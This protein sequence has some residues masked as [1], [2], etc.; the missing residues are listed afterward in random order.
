MPELTSPHSPFH[1]C[2]SAN[3]ALLYLAWHSDTNYSPLIWTTELHS[4]VITAVTDSFYMKRGITT[5]KEKEKKKKKKKKRLKTFLLSIFQ[6]KY[7]ARTSNLQPKME[8]LNW[9]AT[10]LSYTFFL[11]FFFLFFFHCSQLPPSLLST[12]GQKKCQFLRLMQH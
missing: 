1:T 8:R 12:T 2:P 6:N 3:V 9:I 4:N 7:R 10:A 5:K 11:W